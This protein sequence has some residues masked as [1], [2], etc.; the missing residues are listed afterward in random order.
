MVQRFSTNDNRM[1]NKKR[2]NKKEPGWLSC[3]P[4]HLLFYKP[5]IVAWQALPTVGRATN[6]VLNRSSRSAAMLQRQA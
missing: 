2:N 4:T 5:G 1:N 6:T 3:L